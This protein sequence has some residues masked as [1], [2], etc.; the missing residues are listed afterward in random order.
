MSNNGQ[1]TFAEIRSQPSIWEQVLQTYRADQA[2]VLEGW[3]RLSP[4][5]VLF[6]GCGSTYYLS[7]TAA[8]LFQSLT[9]VPSRAL[10]SSEFLF[11]PNH[12]LLNPGETLLVAISRSGTTTETL[13]A[14]NQF[15]AKGGRAV[16]AISCYPEHDLAQISD[17]TLL[18]E[19]AHEQ[20]I[21]QTRSFSS[22][23][24]LA[25]ALTATV[26]GIEIS[27][28]DN[29]PIV[30]R[31]VLEN[32]AD[33]VEGLGRRLDL[34]RMSFLGSGFQYGIAAEA[35]LKMKE[36]SLTNSEAFHFMEF[37]HGPMSM[38]NEQSL[39]VGLVSEKA[40]AH[41]EQ[42]LLE[43]A[44]LGAET[45]GLNTL[46]N[47]C[48]HYLVGFNASLPPWTLPALYL[49]PLQLLAYYRAIAKGLDPDNPRNLEAVVSLDPATFATA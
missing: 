39:V 21:A 45:L 12:V 20:S 18:A 2:T 47:S 26:A 27:P 40:R 33:I 38:A 34:Q 36:M 44:Q 10:P 6:T 48:C 25:K 37:R 11:F 16:W 9:G 5:N 4:S 23:L 49:P 13:Q 43:M 22:M 46:S 41:E 42:V 28:L 15:R 1:Y 31:Q 29:L 14:V 17:L 24:L 3:N 35:M 19:A 8:A 30:L 7:Q 32:T